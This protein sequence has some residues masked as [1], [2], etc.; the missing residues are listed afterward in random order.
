MHKFYK[1]KNA[2]SIIKFF[3]SNYLTLNTYPPTISGL[4]LGRDWSF[5]AKCFRFWQKTPVSYKPSGL[6]CPNWSS[7]ARTS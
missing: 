5:V 6:L 1:L 4:G 2:Q 7:V 3:A